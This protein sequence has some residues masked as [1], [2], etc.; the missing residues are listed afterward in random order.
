M[1]LTIQDI[2]DRSNALILETQENSITPPRVGE[3]T[4]AL[5]ELILQGSLG[6]N[7]IGASKLK[8]LKDVMLLGEQDNDILQRIGTKWT[9]VAMDLSHINQL[10]TWFKKDASGNIYTDE[11]FYS[12]KGISAYGAGT[13]VDG[14]A[15]GYDRLDAWSAYTVEKSGWVLSAFLGN[16]LNDRVSALE[17]GGTGSGSDVVWG[18]PAGGHVSLTV[19]SVMNILALATHEHTISQISDFPASMPASDV[20]EW[21]KAASKPSYSWNEI[22]SKP[23]VFAPDTHDHYISDILNFPTSMPASD[24]YSWAK[25]ATKPSYIASEIGGLG[26]SYQWLTDAYIATWNAK[27]NGTHGHYKSDIVDFAH[28]HV[29]TDITD[30]AHTHTISDITSLQDVLNSKLATSIFTAHA[31]NQT[32]NV[33]HLTDAQ[34]SSL[35]A[36]ASYWKLDNDGN[37]Y[38]EKNVY[39]TGEVSAYGL[40]ST[41]GG[42]GVGSLVT[43]GTESAGSVPLTVEGVTKTLSLASHTHSGYLTVESDPT[44]PAWAKAPAKPSYIASEIGGL[45]ASYRWL[46]DTYIATWNA[47]EPAITKGTTAQYFRG[48]MSL[49]LFPTSLPASDVSSWAK[50]STK[51]SYT[52]SEIGGLGT[53]YRWLTDAYIATWNAKANGTHGHYKSDIVDFTHTHYKSDIIDF[54]HT[55]NLSEIGLTGLS[56]DCLTKFNGSTLV[57]SILI[58][59]GDSLSV[60]GGIINIYNGKI[61][62]YP[63]V[64]NFDSGGMNYA[65]YGLSI[66]AAKVGLSGYYGLALFTNNEE[67]ISILSNGNVGIGTTDPT[68]TLD[69]NGIGKF[70]D[71]ILMTFNT[72]SYPT[73]KNSL[74]TFLKLFDI[75]SVGNLVVKTNLYSTGEVT[76]YSSGTGV[77]GLKL[78]GDMDANTKSIVNLASITNSQSTI[79]L[80]SGGIGFHVLSSNVVTITD[81]GLYSSVGIEA[82]SL[83]SSAGVYGT[84]FNFGKYI[85]KEDAS[86]N[87]GIYKTVSGVETKLATILSTRT[88]SNL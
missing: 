59:N 57:N 22:S 85:F 44:V 43:W 4:Y 71:D 3:L 51:P 18:T 56:V 80:I 69:V 83:T 36:L 37:L 82:S 19:D 20:S 46:T 45:G 2:L 76:A 63:T 23:N 62:Y 27:A 29:K 70:K 5:A 64:A 15:T 34:L 7:V 21:A 8:D 42:G 54:A 16:N 9:N 88:N 79:S 13:G 30:F 24:V 67:R 25:E 47:K 60:V 35:T 72:W 6:G 75:D 10:L 28:S 53:N 81:D 26:S 84:S 12:T 73:D 55:H 50:A 58:D 74:N 86:G 77:S 49:A 52:A 61:G 33:K 11:N 78:M 31:A 17:A 40:G 14:G 65:E 41:G 48:D 1:P 32:T 87:L 39:S 38:T 66:N 68:A